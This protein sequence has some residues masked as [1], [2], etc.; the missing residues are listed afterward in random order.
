MIGT[1]L[2][3]STIFRQQGRKLPKN[4]WGGGYG[5]RGGRAYDGSLGAERPVS[6]V[7]GQSQCMVSGSGSDAP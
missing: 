2:R 4:S 1:R 3:I 7:Q 5:K 6:G